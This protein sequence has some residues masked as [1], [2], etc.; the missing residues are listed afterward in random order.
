[1]ATFPKDLKAQ[2]LYELALIWDADEEEWVQAYRADFKRLKTIKLIDAVEFNATTTTK[3]GESFDIRPYRDA[4]ILIN[5]DVSNSPT[6]IVIDI[7]FSD[8]NS[9]FYKYMQGPFGDLRYEDAAGDKKEALPI[10]LR[11]PYIRASATATGT[12]GT[13]K[14]TLTVKAAMIG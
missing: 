11:V 8:D 6:D 4:L 14:F 2:Q 3:T 13:N 7:E 5:V 9:T 12:S 10:P 1:M